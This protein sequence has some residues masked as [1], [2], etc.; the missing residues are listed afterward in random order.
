[1]L[2][3]DVAMTECT[4][5]WL[6]CDPIQ[7]VWLDARKT[8]PEFESVALERRMTMTFTRRLNDPFFS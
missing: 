1:M 5:P 6:G 8:V 2:A 7:T 3:I 4:L